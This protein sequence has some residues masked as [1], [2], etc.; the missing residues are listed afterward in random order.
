M[1]RQGRII[2]IAALIGAVP[3]VA[4]AAPADID[5]ATAGA[6][7]GQ[8]AGVRSLEITM[9]GAIR[10]QCSLGDVEDMTFGDLTRQGLS[11]QTRV[12]FTC[13]LPFTMSIKGQNG[14]LTHRTMP[15]GQGPYGGRLPYTIGVQMAV[16]HPAESMLSRSFSGGEVQAGGV[17]SSNGGIAMDG[18]LLQVAMGTPSGEAG[19]LAGD[20]SETITITVTPS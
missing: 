4:T 8:I 11:A 13:N 2:A 12:A 3:S 15:N 18:L 9:Q 6:S 5:P 16:R 17:L 10:Q 19:L 20:Y 7:V 14:A 1:H